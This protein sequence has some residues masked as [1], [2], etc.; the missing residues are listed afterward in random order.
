[1]T[2]LHLPSN[3]YHFLALTLFITLKGWGTGVSHVAGFASIPTHITLNR[4]PI[5]AKAG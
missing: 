4:Q 3:G 5:S 2:P 1:L